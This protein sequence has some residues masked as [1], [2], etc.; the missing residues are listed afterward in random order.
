M[1]QGPEVFLT[2]EAMCCQP[3][4]HCTDD[5]HT[6]RKPEQNPKKTGLFKLGAAGPGS[7]RR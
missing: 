3:R 4:A 7:C 2:P 5:S 1:E 6:K